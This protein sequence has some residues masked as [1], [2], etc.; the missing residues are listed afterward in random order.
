MTDIKRKE[1]NF[2]KLIY[3][4]IETQKAERDKEMKKESVQRETLKV[5]KNGEKGVN[6]M[7]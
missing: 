3:S 7:N 5:R 6:I 4:S 1:K 2:D